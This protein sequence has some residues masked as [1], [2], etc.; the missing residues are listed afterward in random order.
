M[1]SALTDDTLQ[2]FNS[3][4]LGYQGLTVNI[5]N[6]RG[7]GKPPGKVKGALARDKRIREAFAL[8]LDR[9]LINKIVFQGMYD[10]ACGPSPPPAN[11]A[12]RRAAPAATWNA[13]GNCSGRRG[14]RGASPSN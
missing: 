5:G 6:S 1:Q 11:W 4:T 2:L 14:R 3:P 12:R 13:R 8:S 9:K 10:T 7:L